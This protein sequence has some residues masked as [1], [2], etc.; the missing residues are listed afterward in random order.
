LNQFCSDG[1]EKLKGEII[2]E[3]MM[4][5][6]QIFLL[7]DGKLRDIIKYQKDRIDKDVSVY[8]NLNE[9]IRTLFIEIDS[10]YKEIGN[11]LDN[12]LSHRIF[13]KGKIDIPNLSIQPI[14][15]IDID[16]RLFSDL[17]KP[18]TPNNWKT[19][20][21]PD[22]YSPKLDNDSITIYLGRSFFKDKGS[23]IMSCV[24]GTNEILI[25]NNDNESI[26]KE[27]HR[28]PSSYF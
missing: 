3:D 12:A 1:L 13:G 14:K 28:F 19:P 7:F 24:P 4:I 8:K 15:K 5:D 23:V 20:K 6:E 22:P 10:Y 2:F 11:Y 17:K 9:V 26:F 25:Y 16:D 21:K 27:D 18:K